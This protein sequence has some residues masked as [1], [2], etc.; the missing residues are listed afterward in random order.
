MFQTKVVDKIKTNI[1]CSVTF[2]R[3]WRRLGDNLEKHDRAREATDGSIIRR[4]RIG[5]W[6]TKAT[7]IHS[8]DVTYC[9]STA[10]V[11]M[12]TRLSVTLTHIAC[13]VR[14]TVA[15]LRGTAVPLQAWSG[16]E[17]SRKLR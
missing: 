9:F 17:G 11:V 12:R 8:Q 7:H 16:P 5:C 2:F 4:M 1:L 15:Y 14:Q 6:T 13:L 3:K 10:T